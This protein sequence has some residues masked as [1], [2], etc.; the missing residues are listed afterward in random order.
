MFVAKDSPTADDK[1]AFVLLVW[2]H[3]IVPYIQQSNLSQNNDV[4]TVFVFSQSIHCSQHLSSCESCEYGEVWWGV[5]PTYNTD[6]RHA[7]HCRWCNA[8]SIDQWFLF[9]SFCTCIHAPI[10]KSIKENWMFLYLDLIFVS[11]LR[12]TFRFSFQFYSKTNE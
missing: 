11:N 12:K 2:H 5:K 9:F 7:I 3:S 4:N 1:H 8:C 6:K 10:T